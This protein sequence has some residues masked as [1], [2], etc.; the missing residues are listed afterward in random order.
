MIK[1]MKNPRY[2]SSRGFTLI[3]LLVVIS[4]IG[5]L[6]SVVLVALQGARQKGVIAG[7]IQFSDNNYHAI[8]DQ[9]ILYWNFDS[10]PTIS[11]TSMNN[12]SGAVSGSAACVTDTPIGRGQA[13]S[14]NGATAITASF[15][16][17][18]SMGSHTVSVWVKLPAAVTT[19]QYVVRSTGCSTGDCAALMLY[20]SNVIFFGPPYNGGGGWITST[21]TL[22]INSW[23][24]LTYTYS[25]CSAGYC[26][27][28]YINGNQASSQSNASGISGN[29][30]TLAFGGSGAGTYLTG[31]TDDLAIYNKSLTGSEVRNIYALGAAKHGLAVK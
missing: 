28:L 18:L 2:G 14:F 24:N 19:T 20:P 16:Q 10:C 8:G 12:V 9:N 13:F 6:A 3:E 5:M 29:I 1:S 22:P 30:S 21:Q 15:S 26:Y 25:P 4:I 17:T 23:V 27:V 7:A 11:D 31:Y